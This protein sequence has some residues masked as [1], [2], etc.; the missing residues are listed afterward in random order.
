MGDVMNEIITTR[1]RYE[2]FNQALNFRSQD[3]IKT[4]VVWRED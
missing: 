1:I 2:N 3:D 4:V